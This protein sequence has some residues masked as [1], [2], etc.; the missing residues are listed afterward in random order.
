MVDETPSLRRLG[1][2]LYEMVTG[3]SPFR[4]FISGQAGQRLCLLVYS[5]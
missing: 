4:G 2:M 3:K 1:A 5:S